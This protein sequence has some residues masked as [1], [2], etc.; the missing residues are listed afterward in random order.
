MKIETKRLTSVD[1]HPCQNILLKGF[2]GKGD[3][4]LRLIQQQGDLIESLNNKRETSYQ[5]MLQLVKTFDEALDPPRVV[6]LRV[7]RVRGIKAVY[8]RL[9]GS[10]GNQPYVR[11][12]QTRRGADFLS[13]ISEKYVLLFADFEKQRLAVNYQYSYLSKNISSANTFIENLQGLASSLA[14]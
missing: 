7:A 1:N 4:V 12:F 10:N 5:S 14:C 3:E 11:L 8:W 13:K 2:K 6:N 9:P